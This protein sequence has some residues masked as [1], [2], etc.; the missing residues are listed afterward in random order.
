MTHYHEFPVL[1]E[2]K[3]HVKWDSPDEKALLEKFHDL[4]TILQSGEGDVPTAKGRSS[5]DYCDY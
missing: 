2:E 1:T 3:K 4:E 5:D